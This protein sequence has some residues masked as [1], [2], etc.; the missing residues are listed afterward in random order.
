M[1]LAILGAIELPKAELLSCW[2]I[3]GKSQRE[4]L[5]PALPFTRDSRS[6]PT[7]NGQRATM[8]TPQWLDAT[9]GGELFPN[10]R[11]APGKV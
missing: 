11:P 2:R 9:H 1:S 8:Q 5:C 10:Q 7:Q 3:S 6:S 4:E